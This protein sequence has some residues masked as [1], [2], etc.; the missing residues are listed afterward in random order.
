MTALGQTAASATGAPARG[1]WERR[2][3]P[4]TA[5]AERPLSAA[6]VDARSATGTGTARPTGLSGLAG[7]TA[8]AGA[9][10][11]AAPGAARRL[12]HEEER[13]FVVMVPPQIETDRLILALAADAHHAAGNGAPAKGAAL[14][15]A[16]RRLGRPTG[17]PGRQR[18]AAARSHLTRLTGLARLARNARLRDLPGSAARP[19][20]IEIV[21][22]DRVLEFLAEEVPLNE[23]IDA[24]RQRLGLFVEQPNR[25]DVLLAAPDEFCFLLAL[26][27]MA[28]HG[29]GDGHQ[30]RHHRKRHEQCR[31]R[32]PACSAL[33]P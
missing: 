21:V 27:L 3:W 14:R 24:R 9:A 32:V 7:L 29:Q 13:P 8:S 5:G 12:L 28:P 4:G 25:P 18:S 26:G 10:G 31:H 30:N 33:T 22:R 16:R 23:Q 15:H 2:R 19:N 6:A 1:K 11:L 20:Q 17:R